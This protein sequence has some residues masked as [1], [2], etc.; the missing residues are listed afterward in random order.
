MENITCGSPYN[1]TVITCSEDMTTLLNEDGYC[2]LITRRDGVFGECSIAYMAAA[3]DFWDTCRFDVCANAENLARAKM[4]AC[5]NLEAF[6]KMCAELGYVGIDWRGVANCPMDCGV[7]MNYAVSASACSPTCENPNAAQTCS[8][9]DTENC[10][11]SS[12]DMVVKDG[13]CVPAS[14]CGCTYNGRHFDIGESWNSVDCDTRYTCETCDSCP[15]PVGVVVN[16]PYS[17]GA[18]LVC[19]DEDGIG[20]CLA[21]IT[22]GIVIATT[23]GRLMLS[24]RLFAV[25]ECT[26][27]MVFKASTS[28]CL[29]TCADPN[30]PANCAQAAAPGCGCADDSMVVT[31]GECVSAATCPCIDPITSKEYSASELFDMSLYSS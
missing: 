20:I 15:M 1:D 22:G 5:R 18:G 23:S 7:N 6:A 8:L 25:E 9:P 2:N 13:D 26:G 4:A 24:F 21:G 29:P 31:E 19:K 14:Q 27:N 28:P 16:A 17:C 3:G 10:V 11:C 12:S 30:A